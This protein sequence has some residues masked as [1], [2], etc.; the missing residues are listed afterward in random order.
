MMQDC[1]RLLSSLRYFL[2]MPLASALHVAPYPRDASYKAPQGGEGES[3]VCLH[4]GALKF[5]C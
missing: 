4:E 2:L 3:I 5:T 1:E